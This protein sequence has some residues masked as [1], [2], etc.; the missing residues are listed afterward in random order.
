MDLCSFH[1]AHFGEVAAIAF[2]TDFLN[3]DKAKH[4][5]ETS[6]AQF[7]GRARETAIGCSALDR[8]CR[9]FPSPRDGFRVPDG[10]LVEESWRMARQVFLAGDGAQRCDRRKAE[11]AIVQRSRA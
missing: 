1:N 7:R 10:R 6:A 2:T 11:C 3:P 9:A 4:D 5:P 8:L